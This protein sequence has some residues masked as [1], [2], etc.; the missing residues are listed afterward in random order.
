MRKTEI[1]PTVCKYKL[2]KDKVFRRFTYLKIYMLTLCLV[3]KI[4]FE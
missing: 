2:R 4:T 3:R 1:N